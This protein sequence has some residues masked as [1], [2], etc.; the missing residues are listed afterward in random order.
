MS[1]S[2]R[3][4]TPDDGEHRDSETR[5]AARPRIAPGE[6]RCKATDL[7]NL[8]RIA[9]EEVERAMVKVQIALAHVHFEA[10]VS[11]DDLRSLARTLRKA[12]A[13][14]DC[15]KGELAGE[16]AAEEARERAQ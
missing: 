11:D 16:V 6:E 9:Q 12:W 5:I 15:I 4:S 10:H 7:D 2:K 13:N 8:R 14:L 3:R 1:A